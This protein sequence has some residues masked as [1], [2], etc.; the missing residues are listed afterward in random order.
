MAD[1]D[2]PNQR[3]SLALSIYVSSAVERA[4]AKSFARLGWLGW[5]GSSP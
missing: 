4:G 1:T 5:G 2:H 3:R